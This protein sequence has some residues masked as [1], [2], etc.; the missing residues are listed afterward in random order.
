MITRSYREPELYMAECTLRFSVRLL[1]S[2]QSPLAPV[3]ATGHRLN[4]RYGRGRWRKRK[5]ICQVRLGNVIRL[6]EVHWYEA[7]GLG[8]YEH[9]IKALL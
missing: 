8:R 1:R 5:G 6:A 3:F 2:R 9:K 7:T 4:R